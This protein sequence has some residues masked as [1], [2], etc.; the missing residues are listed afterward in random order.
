MWSQ[1]VTTLPPDPA[2]SLSWFY[3]VY[4]LLASYRIL[5]VYSHI[6]WSYLITVEVPCRTASCRPGPPV[7]LRLIGRFNLRSYLQNDDRRRV[8]GVI[9]DLWL[10]LA[11]HPATGAS[12]YCSFCR[13]LLLCSLH[14]L[15][16]MLIATIIVAQCW[17]SGLVWPRLHDVLFDSLVVYLSSI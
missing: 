12:M 15:F 8:Y 3:D 6:I 13:N 16:Q 14:H 4:D 5:T 11:C 1:H 7:I 10:C 17:F 9:W 2:L